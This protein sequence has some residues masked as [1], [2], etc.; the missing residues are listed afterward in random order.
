MVLPEILRNLE[1]KKKAKQDSDCS[2]N[3]CDKLALLLC[4]TS[5]PVLK[6]A[7]IGISSIL[8]VIKATDIR[9]LERCLC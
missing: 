8:K 4:F 6:S 5:N 1:L 7:L 9:V 3:T 2:F